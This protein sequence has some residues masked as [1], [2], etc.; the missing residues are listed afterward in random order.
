MISRFVA[1]GLIACAIWAATAYGQNNGDSKPAYQ[2][3]LD[4]ASGK[5]VSPKP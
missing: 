3:I 4:V 2:A 1:S 5:Y